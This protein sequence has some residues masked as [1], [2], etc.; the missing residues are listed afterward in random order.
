LTFVTRNIKPV[1]EPQHDFG[2]KNLVVAGC[3]FTYNSSQTDAC[4]WPYYLKDLGNFETVYDCS[5]PGAGNYHVSHSVQWALLNQPLE[6]E[7]TLVVIMWSGNDRDDFICSTDFL[8]NAPTKYC[9][10]PTVAS[11]ISGGS[12]VTSAGNTTIAVNVKKIKNRQSRAVENFLYMDLLKTWLDQKGYRSVFLN[13]IDRQ[14]PSRTTDF[15]IKSY[16]PLSCQQRLDEMFGHCQDPYSFCL[17]NNLLYQDD[18]HPSAN[19]H[20]QW[21]KDILIPYLKS[22]NIQ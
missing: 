2:F 21:T 13:Y 8:G 11:A 20:L 18:F 5:L 14:L 17:K 16:L 4:T 10:L 12:H 19:G 7:Q 15:E 22:L 6:Q 3:S 1:F 9:Y